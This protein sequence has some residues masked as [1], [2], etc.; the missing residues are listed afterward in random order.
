MD[1]TS[2]AYLLIA[3]TALALAAI[4]AYLWFNGAERGLMRRRKRQRKAQEASR[5]ARTQAE[6]G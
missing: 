2:L 4:G 3:V 6:D 1:R 5:A